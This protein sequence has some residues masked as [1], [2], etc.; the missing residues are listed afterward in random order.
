M[1]KVFNYYKDTD[2]YIVITF[3]VELAKKAFLRKV[4]AQLTYMIEVNTNE[5][6][7]E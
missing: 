3:R 7:G 5:N 6:T 4:S 1:T 2:S